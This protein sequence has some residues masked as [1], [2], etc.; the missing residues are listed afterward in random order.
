MADEQELLPTGAPASPPYANAYVVRNEG[1]DMV[2]LYLMRLP[3]AFTEA[4]R[5]EYAGGKELPAPV[6]SSVTLTK[7]GAESVADLLYQILGKK[8]PE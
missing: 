7:A 3:P 1:D 5:V 4:L 8:P 2:T 6:V